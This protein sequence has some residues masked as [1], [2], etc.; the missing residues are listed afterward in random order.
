M[1]RQGLVPEAL[2]DVVRQLGYWRTSTAAANQP[3]ER[4]TQQRIIGAGECRNNACQGQG[5]R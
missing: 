4:Q 2:V 1:S 3:W 5:A